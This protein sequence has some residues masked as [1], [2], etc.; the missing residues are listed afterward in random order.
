MTWATPN[1]VEL[2]ILVLAAYRLFRFAS[3][4]TF[5]PMARI[6]CWVTGYRDPHDDDPALKRRRRPEWLADLWACP[7]CLGWWLSLALVLA[8]WAWPT[9]A[10]CF[11]LPWAVSGAAALVMARLDPA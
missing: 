4:D 5:E 9:A 1:A 10:I 7:F 6:R 11:A 2:L 8:W 3:T